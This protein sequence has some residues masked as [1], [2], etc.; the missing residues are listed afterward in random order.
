MQKMSMINLFLTVIDP[1]KVGRRYVIRPAFNLASNLYEETLE[2]TKNGVL[3]V[4]DI[5]LRVIILL[6]AIVI[7]LWT[8]GFMYVAFYY[9]YMPSIAHTRPVHMQ[10]KSCD[11]SDGATGLWKSSHDAQGI[12]SYPSA[13]VS[14]TRKQQ[15]LMVGQPYRVLV[16]L[17]MP[18]SPKNQEA[19]M[20]MV[21]AEMRDH[22]GTLRGHSCRSAMLHYK[23]T[24]HTWISTWMR[25]PLYLMNLREEKQ[26]VT[27]ELFSSY[28][29]DEK[30]S[31]TDVYIEIQSKQI[32]FYSVLLQ[33]TAHFTGLRY[34]M[35]HWPILS[36]V[37]GICTNLFV[38]T[39]VCL[40]SWYHWSDNGEQYLE[41]KTTEGRRRFLRKRS[42]DTNEG[43]KSDEGTMDDDEISII[44]ELSSDKEEKS[45]IEGLRI[46]KTQEYIEDL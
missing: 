41:E 12:C 4:R 17:D 36:A 46:R 42:R 8:A 33:I 3:S 18:E 45:T 37:V 32:Q 1:F 38:I 43:T 11:I 7:V 22:T 5:I 30:N 26:E 31:V 19:G 28:Q 16:T 13:H 21:C 34:F 9:A 35:F 39:I 29:D 27:V 24:L 2:K 20:F 44:D 23:S 10:F 6:L 25:I 14:L 15:L 40:M